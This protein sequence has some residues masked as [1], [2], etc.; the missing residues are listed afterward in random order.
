M[1]DNRNLS[2]T[3]KLL[4]ALGFNYS[5][6][7][8]GQ[9]SFFQVIGQFFGNI[10]RKSLQ[11]MMDWA[12]LEPFMPRKMRPWLLRRIGCHV[13]K[14]VFIGDFVRVDLQ[15]AH[16]IYI[17]DYAH[18]TSD[19][20]LLCHQRDLRNYR[21]GDNAA[22]CG[23]KTGEIHIGKGVMIGMR[24]MIMPGVT[25]G[26]GAVVGANSLVT[27]SIPSYTI[28]TGMP[29]RVVKTVPENVNGNKDSNN[30]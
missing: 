9:V 11:S 6:E 2:S 25:I 22:L 30:V 26:D 3:F 12:I 16:M 18:I 17:G 15:H 13:G 7:E 28:A 14:N 10:R 23:Y 21:V 24:S 4:R 19:C 1:S 5:E 27:K 20:R 29:A 8:Y